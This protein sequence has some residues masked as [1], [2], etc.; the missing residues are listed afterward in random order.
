MD[1]SVYLGS[2]VESHTMKPSSKV[3]AL[4]LLALVTACGSSG[5]DKKPAIVSNAQGASTTYGGGDSRQGQSSGATQDASTGHNSS[6][7]VGAS[8]QQD[9][10][11]GGDAS[12]ASNDAGNSGSGTMTGS[13]GVDASGL[14][15]SCYK[16]DDFTCKVEAAIVAQ[17]NAL[18]SSPLVQSFESSFVA[19]DWSEKQAKANA[20]SHDG[21]PAARQQLLKAEFPK[22]SWGFFAE[23]VAMFGG[24]DNSDPEAVAKK[25]VTMWYN[26]EGH[27]KNMLGNYGHIGA[28]VYQSGNNFYATQIFY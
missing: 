10:A 5:E 7:S 12:T 14:L 21:F 24:G 19:R 15:T 9:P 3:L 11:S 18:R 28:G 6:N 27:R 25:F 13:T 1:S 17:T 23:N 22:A 8:G 2:T 4:G 26:S 20:I 16:A